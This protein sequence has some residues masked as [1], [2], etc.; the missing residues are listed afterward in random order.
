MAKAIGS[1]I[2]FI[3]VYGIPYYLSKKQ[4]KIDAERKTD[5]FMRFHFGD[6]YKNK[7]K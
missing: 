5:E 4:E 1:I 2:A 7:R 3:L 6:D